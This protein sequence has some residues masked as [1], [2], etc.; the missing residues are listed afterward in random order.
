M[1]RHW[2]SSVKINTRSIVSYFYSILLVLIF[3]LKFLARTNIFN[4][5]EMRW[6]VSV[7]LNRKFSSTMVKNCI[8]C[9]LK[10]FILMRFSASLFERFL[11]T[12]W[13]IK[14]PTCWCGSMLLVWIN[15][16]QP[17]SGKCIIFWGSEIFLSLPRNFRPV[18]LNTIHS[19]FTWCRRKL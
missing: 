15:F 17:F 12:G 9:Y 5:I 13:G 18:Y 2:N 14:N 8:W 1:I 4:Y 6:W 11:Q 7:L 10:F 16:L 3:T 19:I